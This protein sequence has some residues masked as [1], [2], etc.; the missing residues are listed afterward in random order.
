MKYITHIIHKSYLLYF[1]FLLQNSPVF[2]ISNNDSSLSMLQS[3][4]ITGMIPD[5]D[6]A[7]G[8][9]F[10]DFNNDDHPDIYFTCFRNLNRL[11][12]NN[13]GIIPF[14][15]RTIVSGT[16]G[17][18]MVTGNTNLELGANVA[19]YNNDGLADLFIAGW[20]KTHKLLR[21]LGDVAFE[22]VTLNLNTLGNMDANQGLWLD[23]DNDGFLD[24]YITDEHQSNRMFKNLQNGFFD[25]E[26]W[27]ETFIDNA[28]SQGASNCDLDM[29]GDA[30]IYV[31]NWFSP[32]YLLINDGNGLFTRLILD[33]PTLV[34]SISTNS[35]S[36]ADLDN[37][38]DADLLVAGNNGYVYMY[39]NQSDSSAIR[40]TEKTDHPFYHL[41]TRV[42]GLLIE[43]FNLDGWLDCFITSNGENRL[44][45][46]NRKGGFYK[47]YDTDRKEIYSTGASAADLDNDGDL[48][49]IVANKTDNSQVYLNP[50]NSSQYLRLQFLGVKSNRDAIGTKVFFYTP[51][52][53]GRK[54]LGYR[55]VNVNT[56][57]LSSKPPEIVIG[58]RGYSIIDVEAVFPSGET[59]LKTYDHLGRTYTIQEFRNITKTYHLSLKTLKFLAGRQEFWT[60]SFL[61]LAIIIIITTYLFLGLKRYNWTSYNI[62][63]QLT[64]WF[65]ISLF[66]FIFLK[67]ANTYTILLTILSMA[68]LSTIF[69]TLYSENFLRQRRKREA[70]H[71]MLSGLSDQIINIHDNQKLA[72]E[73]VNTFIKHPAI[74]NSSFHL[75]NSDKLVENSY[76]SFKNGQTFGLKKSDEQLLLQSKINNLNLFSFAD[77]FATNA[78]LILPAKRKGNIYGLITILMPKSN[79]A[80]NQQD[81]EQLSSIA[82]QAAIAIENNNYI[83]ETA[84]L[85]EQLTSKKIRE[86]YVERLEKTNHELDDKNKELERLF[87]ELQNKEA[88]LI[89]SEKMASLGQLVAGISHE[90]NNP[91]SFIYSN[92]K[93]ITD[94]INDL[95]DHLKNI[96]NS[97]VKSE[98]D[99]VIH[100]LREIIE[101]SSN[102]SRILKDI[103]QNLKNFSRLDQAE[104]KEARF[105]EII[106]SCLKIVKPQIPD[107]IKINLNIT[108]DP[109]FFCNPGQLNQV[110]VNLITNAIQALKN[111]GQI[112]IRSRSEME[113]LFLEVNDNG[114]GIPAK[115]IKNIFDPF[116]TTKPVNEGTGLGLSISYSIIQ[117][118]K[119]ELTVQSSENSGTTFTINLPL[120]LE[121]L[122]HNG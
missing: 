23:V 109:S 13:G 3:N 112:N 19:D 77:E 74:K 90:L 43:D 89:H 48:D 87:R 71:Q 7:Y 116:F 73:I 117:K 122:Q 106:D 65:L 16:G 113:T 20:G 49:I 30:D 33:L 51:T 84:R 17:Y 10:R 37:D 28:T 6:N 69:L 96:N 21:N 98:I 1:F 32:D 121:R 14:V 85:I 36:F 35:S 118:H 9:A 114:P 5:I 95:S 66:L 76:S 119:G 57:Y 115:I 8:V 56:S 64:I 86:E 111:K 72:E 41:G 18:L 24:L 27:T 78:N 50:T 44:Y 54:F 110:F 103:V 80:I 97:S 92:M 59:I 104:W 25:E 107:K 61:I 15:D 4:Q 88:Q 62:S 55:E 31:S 120:N 105:S 108:D 67:Q 91:I 94:Y 100:E 83:K 45:L 29:D 52:D 99:K 60:N 102:G 12:I 63:F 75:I 42:F 93:V 40:F 53:S 39:E 34:D 11:L 26:I 68:I 101:D 46:N 47:N 38:G 2:S 81:L 22:D 79:S 70:I 82:G 58:T